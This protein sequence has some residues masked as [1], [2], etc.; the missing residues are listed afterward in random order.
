MGIER[1]ESF[2]FDSL[3]DADYE[4]KKQRLEQQIQA[5][6]GLRQAGDLMVAAFFAKT[7]PKERADKQQVYLAMLSGTFHDDALAASVQEIREQL[8]AGEK[9]ITPFHWDLE[10]PEVFSDGRGGFDVFVGNPPFIGGKR[11]ST[12]AGD[13]FKEWLQTISVEGNANADLVAHFFRRCHSHLRR[14]G[15]MR[16]I[17][18]NTICQGDTRTT[19]L[20]WICINGGTIYS[21]QRRFK[22]PGVAAVVVSTVHLVK[23]SFTGKKYLDSRPVNQITAFL[24]PNGGHENPKPLSDN[25]GLCFIGSVVLGM[26]FTFDDSG[27]ADDETPGIPSPIGIMQRLI[28]ENPKNAEVIFPYIGG[29]E[30]NTSPTH[31]HHRYVINFGELSEGVCRKEWPELMA[32]VERKVKPERD[33]KP[34]SYSKQWWLFGRRNQAGTLALTHCKNAM[35]IALTSN[36]V[37]LARTELPGNP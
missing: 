5:S 29:E 33:T 4:S 21:A 30:V 12:V 18:T 2:G 1:R 37:A 14:G 24:F 17:A 13:A 32:I 9:G 28:E 19:G 36:T 15:A 16:L 25:Q 27:I 22:W 20:R 3:S 23:D 26:G 10:F 8:A 35:V 11:I 6:E 34:G 7:K 31:A